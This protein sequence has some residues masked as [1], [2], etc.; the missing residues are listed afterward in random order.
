M[1]TTL[2]M[3]DYQIYINRKGVPVSNDIVF[4]FSDMHSS[5]PHVSFYFKFEFGFEMMQQNKSEE[6]Y[7]DC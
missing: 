4:Y 2:V 7:P 5:D 3:S 6:M 1:L